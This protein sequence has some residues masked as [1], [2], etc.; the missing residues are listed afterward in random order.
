[1]RAPAD[2]GGLVLGSALQR[3]KSSCGRRARGPDATGGA[4]ELAMETREIAQKERMKAWMGA[5]RPGEEHRRLACV[6]GSK[7]AGLGV[8]A[9]NRYHSP[10]EPGRWGTLSAEQDE[11]SQAVNQS[12]DR[13]GWSR[14]E[15]G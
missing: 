10:P 11:A 8:T 1:M 6:Q 2:L 7:A 15:S 9:G 12:P 4:E 5:G 13:A 3:G 14:C